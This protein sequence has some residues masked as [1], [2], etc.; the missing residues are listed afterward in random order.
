MKKD[1]FDAS[2]T[3]KEVIF[4]LWNGLDTADSSYGRVLLQLEDGIN[5]NFTLSIQ[6]GSSSPYDET[7]FGTALTPTDLQTFS[8]Y[9]FRMYN[10]DSLLKVDFYKDG[11]LLESKTS[12]I[13]NEITGALQ[14]NL[15]A[16]TSPARDGP[17][18]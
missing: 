7:H 14:A 16:L 5:D 15:G 13:I 3:E 9:A 2:L 6:S 10:D 18:P 11:S 17:D 12:L 4:D 8:H 1:S